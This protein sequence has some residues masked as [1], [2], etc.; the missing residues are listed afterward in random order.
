MEK[1]INLLKSQKDLSDSL[2][3][4]L[5]SPTYV[6]YLKKNADFQEIIKKELLTLKYFVNKNNGNEA[7]KYEALV[8]K[9]NISV[10]SNLFDKNVEI[11]GIKDTDA[12]DN[13]NY[14]QVYMKN[15]F[16]AN[17][18]A[19]VSSNANPAFPQA[20]AATSLANMSV[21][22]LTNLL[23]TNP[24]VFIQAKRNLVKR[25]NSG[26]EKVFKSYPKSFWWAKMFYAI[27]LIVTGILCFIYSIALLCLSNKSTGLTTTDGKV[28]N[29][30]TFPIAL[31]I[32]FITFY[33]ISTGSK[34][35]KYYLPSSKSEE[36]QDSKYSFAIFM[37]N[38]GNNSVVLI[39]LIAVPLI[40]L[41]PDIRFFIPIFTFYLKNTI[42][43]TQAILLTGFITYIGIIVSI[44]ST[45]V[46]YV[47]MY[48]THPELD[49][50]AFNK[51]RQEEIDK[52]LS[53][54]K[55]SSPFTPTTPSSL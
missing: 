22:N 8:G 17:T 29:F 27:F 32:L 53:D 23:Q 16:N 14:L 48:L 15:I 36:R 13:A 45:I 20:A 21:E 52:I 50:A 2:D 40:C 10:P 55:P 5:S 35:I 1:E 3:V 24:S 9:Y 19:D 28:V 42:P 51:I 25:L 44:A 49:E 6:E 30:S 34:I 39:T 11:S 31:F 38:S 18:K 41:F 54:S 37:Y 26:T 46:C 47:I 7:D 43:Y 12:I 33:L 4:V